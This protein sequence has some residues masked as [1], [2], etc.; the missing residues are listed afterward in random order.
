M[1]GSLVSLG[2]WFAD[3]VLE[4]L[5]KAPITKYLSSLGLEAWVVAL[6]A[7]VLAIVAVKLFRQTVEPPPKL[8]W[9]NLDPD[10]HEAMTNAFNDLF[11]VVTVA[12]HLN[13]NDA[14]TLE[15][16]RD[17]IRRLARHRDKIRRLS[18]HS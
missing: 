1:V 12:K 6:L 15:V 17:Q 2:Q 13:E 16:F 8:D 5:S 9:S 4:E 18:Q 14:A 7:P 11:T 10:N 3:N